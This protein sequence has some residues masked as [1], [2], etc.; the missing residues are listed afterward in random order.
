MGLGRWRAEEKA[1]YGVVFDLSLRGARVMSQVTMAPGDQ[2]A[3]SLRLPHHSAAMNLDAT[4]RW[5]Q[6]HTFGL[7]FG[8]VTAVAEMRLRKCLAKL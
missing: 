2:L 6:D 4:V 8:S 5:R 1:G 7:E 3:V